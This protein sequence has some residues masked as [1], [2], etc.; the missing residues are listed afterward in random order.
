MSEATQLVNGDAVKSRISHE[1]ID[2]AKRLAKNGRA[3]APPAPEDRQ[4]TIAPPKMEV[5]HVRIV[6]TAPLCMNRFGQKALEMM[7]ETQAL[8]SVAKKGK[9]REPKDF[10]RCY[11]QSK[12]VSA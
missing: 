5:A 3:K 1:D 12:H 2:T 11:E 7:R 4:I 10:A 9:K 8:G 6:G